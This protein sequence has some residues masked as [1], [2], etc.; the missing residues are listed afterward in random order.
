MNENITDKGL[1]YLN[2]IQILNIG[3]SGNITDNGLFHLKGIRRL[4]LYGT[5]I[6][7]NGLMYLKGINTLKIHGGKIT[8]NGL[9]YIKGIHR[10]HMCNGNNITNKGLSNLGGICALVIKNANKITSRGF[11]YLKGIKILRLESWF[12]VINYDDLSILKGI[13]ELSLKLPTV[14]DKDGIP[15]FKGC[16]TKG[17]C[18]GY[19]FV[20]NSSNNIEIKIDELS[21][22]GTELKQLA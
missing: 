11:K 9:S 2:G 19:V 13:K 1:S 15:R 8:N 6:T 4:Y 7:D 16:V 17:L 10:L 14:I 3:Y 21:I 5:K 20:V 22:L 18:G 12:N